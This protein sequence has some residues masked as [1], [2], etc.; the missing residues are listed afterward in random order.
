MREFTLEQD[1]E[2]NNESA[3]PPSL[4]GID[5]AH[6]FEGHMISVSAVTC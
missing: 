6:A 2:E 1:D 3:L 4:G 5:G